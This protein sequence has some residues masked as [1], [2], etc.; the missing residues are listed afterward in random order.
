MTLK[1]LYLSNHRLPTEKAYGIQITSMC[2]AFARTGLRVHLLVPKRNNPSGKSIFEYYGIENNFSMEE[3]FSPDFHFPGVLAALA[4]V[5]KMFIS[6]AVLSFHALFQGG[7]I[8]F[9]RDELPLCLLS[10]FRKNLIF[11]IHRYTRSRLLLYRFLAWRGVSY[12]AITQGLKNDLV[13]SGVPANKILVAPDGVRL[14]RFIDLPSQSEARRR[15]HLPEDGP[16]IVYAGHLYRWKGVDILAEAA[17]DVDG[18]IIFVGGT[19]GDIARLRTNYGTIPNIMIVGH[20]QHHEIPLWLRAAD[21]LVL[22]NRSDANISERYTSPLKLFEYMAA[23][24]P[25]VASSLPSIR[26]IL[27]EDNAVFVPPNDPR[28]L[29]AGIRVALSPTG[30]QRALRAL[31]DVQQY[32]WKGRAEHILRF[33]T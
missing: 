7:D 5:I 33:L 23:G 2:D 21:V 27:N 19:E 17:Q 6:S 15:L 10:F 14:E 26:E 29:A 20:R 4:F 32:D 28:A 13:L 22:P 8:I 18:R 9:S 25:I 11:E 30:R 31:V 12:I 3:V 16:I 1:L 24:T